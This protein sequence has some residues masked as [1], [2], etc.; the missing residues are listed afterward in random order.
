VSQQ[1][2]FETRNR[3]SGCSE[4][5][6]IYKFIVLFWSAALAG[7]TKP[8]LLLAVFS[9]SDPKLFFNFALNHQRKRASRSDAVNF[10]EDLTNKESET[11][12]ATSAS[13]IGAR[14]KL[15]L[16]NSGLGDAARCAQTEAFN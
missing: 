6:S 10:H 2:A 16:N 8:F 15:N 7:D 5:N 13:A 12:N 9:L 1:S 4:T 3:R 14:Q 11:R